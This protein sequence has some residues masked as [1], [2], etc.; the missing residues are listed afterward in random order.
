[1]KL[2]V[3]VLVLAVA[4]LIDAGQD[5]WADVQPGGGGQN[6]L[7]PG[8]QYQCSIGQTCCRHI[9]GSWACCPRPHVSIDLDLDFYLL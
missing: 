9:G 3:A 6:I 5:P 1:M 2:I 7:C 8:G 4:A